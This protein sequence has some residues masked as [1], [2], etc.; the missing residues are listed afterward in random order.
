[1][2]EILISIV[3]FFIIGLHIY[4]HKLIQ[5][6]LNILR[7]IDEGSHPSQEHKANQ[8]EQDK[9]PTNEHDLSDIKRP[10]DG[11]LSPREE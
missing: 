5:E 7:R 2:K 3:V 6:S 10:A 11:L 8:S 4:L 9:K 1:M